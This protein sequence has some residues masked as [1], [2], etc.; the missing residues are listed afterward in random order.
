M[1]G[2]TSDRPR[3]AARRLAMG[4]AGTLLIA[5]VAGCAAEDD[6]IR[7]RA[8]DCLEARGKGGKTSEFHIVG[9]AAPQA[10]YKM[11]KKADRC[12]DITNGYALVGTRRHLTRLCLTLNAKEGD[13]FYQEVG[14]PTGKASKVTCDPSATYRI[15]KVSD[16]TTDAS[17]CGADVPN[18][19]KTP[20]VLPRAIVYRHPAR[21]LC[22]DRP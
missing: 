13:C 11:I 16:G 6:P 7:A 14:F 20:D 1:T 4:L 9:C 17:V 21:T 5:T 10:A 22:A 18:W 19:T 3:P 8:G 15:T 12:D 2:T